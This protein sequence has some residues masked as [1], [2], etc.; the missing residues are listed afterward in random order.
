ME[1]KLFNKK[2]QIHK[3]SQILTTTKNHGELLLEQLCA[4]YN[5][6]SIFYC[7]FDKNNS[8]I[9]RYLRY[10]VLKSDRMSLNARVLA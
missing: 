3:D 6:F 2:E 9:N 10:T 1:Q 5:K 8:V 4:F 7:T